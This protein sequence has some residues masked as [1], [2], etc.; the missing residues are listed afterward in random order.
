M[1]VHY[2]VQQAYTYCG[3]LKGSNPTI[4]YQS[5]AL[6]EAILKI[7]RPTLSMIPYWLKGSNPTIIYQSSAFIAAILKI[8]RPTLSMIL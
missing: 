8:G 7:G 3:K 4:I 1:H 2:V 5:S 6:I